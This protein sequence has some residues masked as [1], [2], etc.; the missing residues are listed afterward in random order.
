MTYD[1]PSIRG[2]YEVG[3]V[4][5]S[6]GMAVVFAAVN[7]S[8]ERP[9]AI[10]Q[11]RA[12]YATVPKMVA[13]FEREARAAGRIQSKHVVQILDVDHDDFGAPVIVMERLTGESLAER[14]A[15]RQRLGPEEAIHIT[16]QVLAGVGA[17]HD[18]GVVHR[19][20]KAGNV[21]L[22]HEGREPEIVKILDFGISKIR[23]DDHEPLTR[24]G[25][26]L[27]TFSHMAP[28]QIR[29]GHTVTGRA[30]L[31]SV[32]VVLYAML[33]G[34]MPFEADDSISLLSR[35]LEEPHTPLAQR[36]E[37]PSIVAELFDPLINR[38][39]A[40]RPSDR[41]A[42][43]YDMV[44]ALDVIA[45]E[46][47]ARDMAG[48][49]VSPASSPPASWRPSTPPSGVPSPTGRRRVMLAAGAA[50]V[51]ALATASLLEQS[52]MTPRHAD[53]RVD[54]EQ[55]AL[56][57]RGKA[58]DDSARIPVDDTGRL[59]IEARGSSPD[60]VQVLDIHVRHDTVVFFSVPS[61]QAPLAPRA[62]ASRGES[63]P[64]IELDTPT[65]A[66]TAALSEPAET[67]L[68]P[69]GA[70]TVIELPATEPRP[71]SKSA[72][73][74]PPPAVRRPAVAKSSAAAKPKHAARPAK[75]SSKPASK[76]A[77]TTK[78]GSSDVITRPPF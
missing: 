24:V 10:K 33:S 73:P 34:H 62:E 55:T 50:L 4:V 8:T 25:E 48:P 5:G 47:R 67:T 49:V 37:V 41:F 56:T 40:K 27:G 12:R 13:R 16:Q 11:L 7:T 39:L 32:G 22:A 57:A 38:A 45:V 75:P 69:D 59:R 36:S 44:Q 14:L 9:V 31:W 58:V 19:D 72:A 18:A 61:R 29:K 51:L 66:R 15:R 42:S 78:R 3:E 52:R 76:S 28:E 20:L 65:S 77:A 1:K 26:A 23:D 74:A 64:P 6:G 2:K 53:V 60:P 17:A 43:A 63:A 35:I 70:D 46:L 21:F 30:D 71:T 68:P 54:P